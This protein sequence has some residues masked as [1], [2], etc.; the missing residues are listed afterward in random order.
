MGYFSWLSSDTQESIVIGDIVTMIFPDNSR[1]TGEYDGYG[2][3][4]GR[5]IFYEL[6]KYMGHDLPFEEMRRIGIKNESEYWG[7]YLVFDENADV[8]TLKASQPCPTQGG[9]FGKPIRYGTPLPEAYRN[10]K[11]SAAG[12]DLWASIFR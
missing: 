11:I 2:C 7:I 3:I 12:L 10:P 6:A 1:F 9:Q 8:H 4:G 5:D